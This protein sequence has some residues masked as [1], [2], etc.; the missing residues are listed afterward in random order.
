[1]GKGHHPITR[2]LAFHCMNNQNQGQTG[3]FQDALLAFQNILKQHIG[4]SETLLAV[5]SFPEKY[6]V[7]GKRKPYREVHTFNT[8]VPL[9][10]S[11]A[12]PP[13]DL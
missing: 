9:P 12:R 7:H 6:T 1:M 13:Q 8:P 4:L 5:T 10:T 11:W 3:C 2:P